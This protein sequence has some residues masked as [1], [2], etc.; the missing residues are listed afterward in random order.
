MVS[1][2]ELKRKRGVACYFN[3]LR[4]PEAVTKYMDRPRVWRVELIEA[5]C[6]QEELA[7]LLAAS[8]ARSADAWYTAARVW[9]KG[10]SWC[11]RAA[12]SAERLR[13]VWT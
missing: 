7:Q 4:L 5:G 8:G 11:S 6:T 2:Q 3:Q 13:A 1:Y 12:G 9:G 10:F